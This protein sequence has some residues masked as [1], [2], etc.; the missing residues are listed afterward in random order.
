ML[1]NEMQNELPH[2]RPSATEGNRQV[3]LFLVLTHIFM[4]EESSTKGNNAIS[5]V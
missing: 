3:L 1:V 5:R 4:H 2:I